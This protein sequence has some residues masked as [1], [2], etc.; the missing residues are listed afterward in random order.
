MWFTVLQVYRENLS[1]KRVKDLNRIWFWMQEK[2]N[3]VSMMTF[4]LL[5]FFSPSNVILCM[6][7][8]GK[9]NKLWR[10]ERRN[11]QSSSSKAFHFQFSKLKFS[12]TC[13]LTVPHFLCH[14]Y[15]LWLLYHHPVAVPFILLCRDLFFRFFTHFSSVMGA[16]HLATTNVF[17]LLA[18]QN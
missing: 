18:P 5:V 8:T 4:Q 13:P 12:S 3:E 14:M 15:I 9:Q 7:H 2:D 11:S 16:S 1:L 10:C 6:V 17:H